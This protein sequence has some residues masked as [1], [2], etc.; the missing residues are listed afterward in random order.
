[1][2]HLVGF[3]SIKEITAEMLP[4]ALIKLCFPAALICGVE[5]DCHI[6]TQVSINGVGGMLA[7]RGVND[8]RWLTGR[9]DTTADVAIVAALL[10]PFGFRKDNVEENLL[11]VFACSLADCISTSLRLFFVFGA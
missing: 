8:F 7:A 5:P 3:F 6:H 9:V 1:M 10:G 2:C 11:L 4:K